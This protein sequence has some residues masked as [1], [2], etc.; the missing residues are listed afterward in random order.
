MIHKKNARKLLY[1]FLI[2]N[3][4][5]LIY[6]SYIDHNFIDID[7]IKDYLEGPNLYIALFIYIILLTLRWLTL[8]PW[9]PLLIAW[10]RIFPKFSVIL[11]VEIAIFFYTLII[12]KY[13][14]IVD[15]KV[16]EKFI[17]YKN[18]IHKYEI[19]YII[20]MC[21]MP[22][23]SINGLAYFFS[24][25]KI[26]FKNILIWMWIGTIISTTIYINL[27]DAVFDFTL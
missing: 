13:N 7:H 5:S 25:L 23:V 27:F 17:S 6:F 26:D 3:I 2:I 24:T 9:T 19:P 18:K 14:S 1:V 8:F 22:W 4:I 15:F 11:S 16:P 21:L 20:L 12:Y 10:T